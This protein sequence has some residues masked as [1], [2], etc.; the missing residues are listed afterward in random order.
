MNNL[1]EASISK[2]DNINNFATPYI[3]NEPIITLEHYKINNNTFHI[4]ATIKSKGVIY[5]KIYYY[6]GEEWKEVKINNDGN[7]NWIKNKVE[8][9]IENQYNNYELSEGDDFYIAAW[10]CKANLET[11]EWECGCKEEGN[12][13]YWYLQ[14]I[15][16]NNE[17]TTN[18]ECIDNDGDGFGNPASSKCKYNELDC[19]DNNKN[20]NLLMQE[21]PYNGVDDDCNASTKDDDL[22]NDNYI[23]AND[24]NDTNQAINPKGIEI[25][26]DNIDQ[27][28]SGS[29]EECLQCGEGSIPTTGCVCAG[30]NEYDGY[31]CDNQWQE[32]PCGT[33][34]TIFHD[35]FESGTA[36]T[37]D[38]LNPYSEVN[39]DLPRTG[40][41]SLDL[42]YTPGTS[43][44]KT[45]QYAGTL[46]EEKKELY[47][48]WYSYFEEDFQQP[49]NGVIINKVQDKDKKW[50]VGIKTK[51]WQGS[52]SKG[53]VNI[54]YNN[55]EEYT[56]KTISNGQWYC[57]EL[58]VK[59]NDE[60]NNNGVIK[61][62]VNNEVVFEKNS[63]KI[64]N[65]EKIGWYEQGGKYEG[66]FGSSPIHEYVDDVTISTKR[67]G[68]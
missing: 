52:S 30:N 64:S 22:D 12:C 31:C 49:I 66:N 36:R 41:Y 33:P 59:S 60:N 61:L 57:F 29:D 38:Y 7:N 56:N 2:N 55:T 25:C 48:K 1:T 9:S 37:W 46:L 32:T 44:L 40:K 51:R 17:G 58:E 54:Y 11:N 8:I 45:N 39:K 14:S 67:I 63:L 20:I 47:F 4:Q 68:C 53:R 35:G 65:G 34:E 42:K 26:G 15:D 21:I 6:S 62:W 23:K 13:N 3:N 24:C 5:K 16:L 27:D 50:A 18:D 28:C 43:D 19:N 10:V